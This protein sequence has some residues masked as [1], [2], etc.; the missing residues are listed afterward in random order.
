VTV[1]VAD[2][3]RWDPGDVREVFHATR[4]RAEAVFEAADGIATLPAFRTWGGDAARAAQ[5]ANEQLRS[6]LDAHGNE[7]LAVARAAQVAADDM[8]KVRSDLS[9]LEADVADAHLAIDPVTSRVMPGPVIRD[10][11]IVL[12]AEMEKSQ[13]RL[14]AIL[15]RAAAVDE[16]LARAIRMATGADPI[17]DSPHDNRPEI[18]DALSKP[19]PDDP[20]QFHDLWQQLTRE[21]RDWLY[22]QNHSIGNDPGMPF[23]DKDNYNRLDL[24]ELTR[25]AQA[26]VDQLARSHPE[27]ARGEVPLISSRE[28]ESWK[29]QWDNANHDLNGYRAIQNALQANDGLPRILGLLDDKGHAAV[30]IGNP[31]K[32]KRNATFVPG[33]GNDLP[34]LQSSMD[35]SVQMFQAA[36]RADP[37]LNPGDVAVTTWMGYDRPMDLLDAAS[38]GYAVNGAANLDAF[39][40]GMR[41]SHEG[42]QSINTVIGHSYGS[43]LV[44][45]AASGG[46]HLDVNNVVAVGSPGML[47]DRAS[48]LSL[49]PGAS[50]YATRARFDPINLA[51]GFTLGPSPTW[52]N[53]GAIQFKAAPGPTTGPGI[54]ALPSVDAHSSYWSAGNPALDNMGRVIAGLTN[55]TPPT[56]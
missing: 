4:S 31:D 23:V 39:E 6:D 8:E 38:S 11:M 28:W 49:D 5:L 56:P 51:T 40:A 33:T 7:S 12:L 45:A 26:Q 19:L 50:V 25:D 24:D 30:S 43:T 22:R 41:V 46:H 42:P 52:D 44:G 18:Q 32:A 14:N 34:H 17:P 36:L 20:K 1:S 35:K 48:D 2:I 55:V 3:D 21:E 27:W 9:Q 37:T 13:E 47:V 53:F 15:A 29:S 16:E 10:P 54:F